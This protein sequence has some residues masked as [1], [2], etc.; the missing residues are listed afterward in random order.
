M[1]RYR[2]LRQAARTDANQA[3]IVKALRAAGGLWVPAGHPIDG[4]AGYQ[5]RWVPIEIKDGAKSASRRRLTEDQVEFMRD[6]AAYR[7]PVAVVTSPEE[8]LAAVG[9]IR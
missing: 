9:A 8:I 7:L 5:S 2:R 6:C 3:E 4:W 1:M